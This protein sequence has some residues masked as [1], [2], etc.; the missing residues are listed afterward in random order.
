MEIRAAMVEYALVK[1]G[2]EARL[3][4]SP[5]CVVKRVRPYRVGARE[6]GTFYVAHCGETVLGIGSDASFSVAIVGGI[7]SSGNSSADCGGATACGGG[8]AEEE[9]RVA[10]S[11]TDVAPRDADARR[12]R[13]VMETY[14]VL[15]E[16]D[17]WSASLKDALLQGAT[18]D[19]FMELGRDMLGCPLAYF[20]RNLI[21]LAKSGD[22]WLRDSLN[23]GS[24]PG[25]YVEDQM[26]PNRAAD[27]VEDVDYLHAAD[28]HGG[29][30]YEDARNR[31]YYGINTFDQG[32]Y[33]ARLVLALPEGERQLR[34]GQEQL[35]DWYHACLDELHSHYAGHVGVVSL[36]ND[37]LHTL[38]RRVLLRGE[39][40]LNEAIVVLGSFD[41]ELCDEYIVAKLV[42]FEGLHWNT[43]SL[44]L[45]GLLERAIAGSCAFPQGQQIVWLANVTK[46]AIANE[47]RKQVLERFT[48]S[49]VSVLR[50]Y[51][52]KAGISDVFT[53]FAEGQS[54]YLQTGIALDIGQTRD[55]HYWY[56]AFNDY[57]FDYLL[58]KSV[59][60][61]SAV[62]VCHPALRALL[63]HDERCGTEY[64]RTLVCFLR[65]S[66]NTTHAAEELFI[67]RTSFMRRMSQIAD[68]ADVDL[69][70]PD[71]VLYLLLS[72]KV[73]GM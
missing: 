53:D 67:H 71:Q 21:V 57:A 48:E 43:V 55:P 25:A 73:L 18:F 1:R 4:G 32:T 29:F 50:N 38:A 61:L 24:E 19:E 68:I 49:L 63:D 42:F 8:E 3:L 69:G 54:A 5:E 9:A 58:S 15:R 14:D 12:S 51:A 16:L 56:Y 64:A 36:Q 30:Y 70:D 11:A 35:V 6:S 17:A 47:T 33:L 10:K 27:L 7:S 37:S 34:R 59:E 52:C 20:D 44:Y 46:A 23:D 66:Q 13:L 28:I 65:N 39:F 72:A 26:P 22:Y 60:E 45:C 62:Q 40:E 41:W 31:M 2:F